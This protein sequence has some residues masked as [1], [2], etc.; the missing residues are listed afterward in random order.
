VSG[1]RL[2]RNQ[3]LDTWPAEWANAMSTKDHPDWRER[4]AFEGPYLG[5]IPSGTSSA[6]V[7]VIDGR[8]GR[9]HPMRFVA[10]MFGVAQDPETLS[11]SP[12]F[13]WAVAYDQVLPPRPTRDRN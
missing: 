9:E 1:T 11:L 8:N 13:G 5:Q 2:V 12:S 6:P 3:Y 4:D 7:K 10:G